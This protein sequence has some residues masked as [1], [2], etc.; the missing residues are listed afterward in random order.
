MQVPNSNTISGLRDSRT[1]KAKTAAVIQS[2]YIPW[3]GYFA[4]A[5]DVDVFVIYE[6]VQYTKNDWR[7]R[8]QI[9]VGDQVQW[10]SVPVHQRCLEQNFM[11]TSIAAK[12]WARKHFNSLSHA[13][14]KTTGW[15]K[16]KSE[17]SHLYEAA[18]NLDY[19]YQVNR[20]FLDWAFC[21]LDIN[22]PVIHL[23]NFPHNTDPTRRLVRILDSVGANQYLSGPAARGYI[24]HDQFIAA[25]IAIEYADYETLIPRKFGVPMSIPGTS[26]LQH[27][28]ENH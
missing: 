22:T 6:D 19:L 1:T 12:W 2:N 9:K 26:F 16:Y 7:N 24:D 15:R 23:D 13:F 25:N 10:L 3:L 17:L 21:K 27:L 14:S 11:E 18:A 20:L 28:M 4:M 5:A 8:N